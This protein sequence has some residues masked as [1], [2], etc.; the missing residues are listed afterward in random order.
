MEYSVLKPKKL[1]WI[2]RASAALIGIGLAMACIAY[3][4][5]AEADP[6]PLGDPAER[7]KW[8]EFSAT[9]P[10]GYIDGLEVVVGGGVYCFA[11]NQSATGAILDGSRPAGSRNVTIKV[12]VAD[13]A[14]NVRVIPQGGNKSAQYVIGGSAYYTTVGTFSLQD[15]PF[16][17]AITRVHKLF[18]KSAQSAGMRI[19][20]TTQE[21]RDSSGELF[22]QTVG[23]DTDASGVTMTITCP[24]KGALTI[25]EIRGLL[26]SG[27]AFGECYY[28]DDAF[29][30]PE[31]ISIAVEPKADRDTIDVLVMIFWAVCSLGG[32]AFGVGQGQ[33]R[34]ESWADA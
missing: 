7:T 32:Y 34:E 2:E 28:S 13:N 8:V 29:V 11:A 17:P 21:C 24:A 6:L 10:A 23:S 1:D 9:C 27:N 14:S 33:R 25:K 26:Q 5:P 19:T 12:Y 18:C 30:A 22:P 3:H 20:A 16:T 31:V 15:E 4:M